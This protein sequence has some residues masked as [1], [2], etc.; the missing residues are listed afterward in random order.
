MWVNPEKFGNTRKS[1]IVSR[2]IKMTMKTPSNPLFEGIS[3][4]YKSLQKVQK[5]E[6]RYNDLAVTC[7]AFANAKGGQVLGT[8]NPQFINKPNPGE[9]DKVVC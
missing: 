8:A 7:V 9:S 6:R 1:I 4:E 2:E 3:I 5:G